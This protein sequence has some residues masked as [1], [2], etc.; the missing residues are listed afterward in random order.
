[1]KKRE[2]IESLSRETEDDLVQPRLTRIDWLEK[3]LEVLIENGVDAVRITRLADLLGVTR[4]SFYWHFTDR[5][6]LLEAILDVWQNLNT[7]S[8]V[9]AA[10]RPGTL[11]ERILGLFMCWLDADLF[12]PKLDFAVRDWARGDPELQKVITTADQQRMD[13]IIAMFAD[14]GFSQQ[15]AIIRARNF[16][17]IQMGYYALNVKELTSIRISYLP[18]YFETYTDEKL[19][20]EAEQEFR[21]KLITKPAL[22]PGETPPET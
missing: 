7:A 13:A 1:M 17:Y 4:G 12:D 19:T 21:R 9:E 15:Q 22:W 16:Y 20:P 14:H 18:T 11:E 2:L 5:G 10:S 3:A 8:I 6:A